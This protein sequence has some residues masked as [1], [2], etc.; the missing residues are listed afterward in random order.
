MADQLAVLFDL[1]GLLADTE[2]IWTESANILLQRRGHTFDLALKPLFMGRRTDEVARLLVER[3]QLP[4]RAED[5]LF[6]RLAIM[7]DLY[8]GGWLAPMPGALELIGE[9]H[10]GQV[11]MAVVSGSPDLLIRMVLEAFDLTEPLGCSVSSDS[12][13]RGKPA[14]DCYLLAARR[15]GVDPQC[16]VVLEDAPAGVQA[17]LAAGMTCV[18]VPGPEIPPE[19]VASAHLTVSSLTELSLNRLARLAKSHRA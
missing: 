3:Y 1:D 17:A 6:E 5:L 19:Q 8:S 15:L 12:V 13:E 4:D 10:R 14:P 16:C 2:P 11:P 7:E 9:L 18:A